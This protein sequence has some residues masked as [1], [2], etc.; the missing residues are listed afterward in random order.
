MALASFKVG[1][2]EL[3]IPDVS[4]ALLRTPGLPANNAKF[5]VPL[6]FSKLDLRDYLFHV[7]G[8]EILSVRSYVKQSRVQSGRPGLIRPAFKRWHRPRATKFMTVELARPFVWPEEPDDGYVEWGL[9]ENNDVEKEN[10]KWQELHMGQNRDQLVNEERRERMRE[11]AKALLEGKAKWK[12]PEG[13]T[14][15]DF[16]RGE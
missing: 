9:K 4:I 14:G 10:T 5:H 8:V 16:R 6:W 12:A 2:K 13:R 11:Q 7:Y 3:F 15:R 1:A